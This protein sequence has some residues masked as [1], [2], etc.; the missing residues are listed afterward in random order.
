[1]EKKLLLREVKRRFAFSKYLLR[2]WEKEGKLL[3]V[4]RTKAGERIYLEEDVKKFVNNLP[5]Y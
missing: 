3:P 1:M 5:S 2:K 4:G